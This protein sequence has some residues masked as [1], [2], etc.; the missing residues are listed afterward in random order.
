VSLLGN[1]QQAVAT[2]TVA[3]LELITEDRYF[4]LALGSAHLPLVSRDEREGGKLKGVACRAG[5]GVTQ[6]EI[7]F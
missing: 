5:A 7:Y 4:C 3:H 1:N 2:G 6:T